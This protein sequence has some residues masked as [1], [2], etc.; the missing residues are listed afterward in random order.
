METRKLIAADLLKI[1]AVFLSPEEPFT[2][3]SGI[4]SPVYCDNRLTLTAPEV[5]DDVE[6]AIAETVKKHYPDAEVLMGTS[7]AGIAHAAIAAHILHM[8]MGYV[9]SGSKDHGRRNR[10]EG[11]LEKGQKVVIV[12]DLISTGGSV[13]DVAD[14]LREAGAEVLGIVSI[15]TY[16]MK[17][18]IERLSA[19]KLKNIS[20]TDFDC[21]AEAAAEMGYIKPED[22][23]RL[24]AFRNDPSDE[25][26]IG[27]AK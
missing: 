17:K 7:T 26:W 15:F 3:A 21:I 11:R 18:G 27:G 20:L 2:W 16:G 12:E 5:R 9:R 25:S 1:K 14:A 24:I 10:I 19:A 8:P 22:I 6:N 23:K 4:K 13:I